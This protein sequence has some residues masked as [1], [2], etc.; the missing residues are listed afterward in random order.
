MFPKCECFERITEIF[1][2]DVKGIS[3]IHGI[4]PTCKENMLMNAF[5]TVDPD[6]SHINLAKLLLGLI[7]LSFDTFIA[8][9]DY[10]VLG[11]W[12]HCLQIINLF[13]IV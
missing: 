3:F 6:T 2:T 1:K 11:S 5:H 7:Q 10:R 4:P 9:E 13:I 12:T 8:V